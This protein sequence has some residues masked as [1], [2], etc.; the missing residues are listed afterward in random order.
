MRHALASPALERLLVESVQSRLTFELV[1]RV[2]HSPEFERALAD[3]MSSPAVRGALSQATTSLAGEIAHPQQVRAG[4]V[5]LDDAA[6]RR[7]RRWFRRP[8]RPAGERSR[9]AG[10]ATRG[11]ALVLDAMLVTL[12]FVVGGALV[13]LV[14]S[15]SDTFGRPGS[16][17]RSW[18][19]AGD[20]S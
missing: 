2:V 1:E 5:R 4:A 13:G 10:F 17:G 20:S 18:E 11:V 14:A 12:V 8:P 3:A 16:S 15:L 6:E 19:V 7:P 9:Y